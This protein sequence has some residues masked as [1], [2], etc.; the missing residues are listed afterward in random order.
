[1]SPRTLVLFDIDGTLLSGGPARGAFQEA[2]EETF[3]TAGPIS[4]WEFSGKTDPQI[5]RELLTEAGIEKARIDAGFAELWARYLGKMAE[6]LPAA[7]PR[8]LPGTVALLDALREERSVGI[9]LLTGNVLDG[10]RLKLEWAGFGADRFAVGAY[11]SDHEARDELPPIAIQ[12]ATIHWGVEFRGVEVVIVGDTPRDVDC[13]KRSGTRTVAVATGNFDVDALA[14]C[15]ADV[16]FEDFGPTER[17]VDAI[18][19]H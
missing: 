17:V 13:G 8:Q 11:G 16:V 18:L 15:G 2:L 10:A 6:R 7:P 19:G 4:R 3:G 1:V 12:R 9:G 5:A 14:G